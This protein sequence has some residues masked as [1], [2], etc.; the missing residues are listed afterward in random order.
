MASFLFCF[1]VVFAL[2]ISVTVFKQ[3]LPHEYKNKSANK[4]AQLVPL[5]MPTDC[6][7]TWS[8]KTT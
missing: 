8:P 4:G 3:I 6:W 5:E 1:V 7:K 2:V